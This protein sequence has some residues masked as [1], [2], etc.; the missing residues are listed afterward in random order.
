MIF[1]WNKI[2]PVTTLLL[3]PLPLAEN[4]QTLT[5]PA[6]FLCVPVSHFD[7]FL[8]NFFQFFHETLRTK[9]YFGSFPINNNYVF[10]VL[11]ELPSYTKFS[12]TVLSSNFF[13]SFLNPNIHKN[14]VSLCSR[15]WSLSLLRQ[16][17][18]WMIANN[19]QK[20][21]GSIFFKKKPWL[22]ASPTLM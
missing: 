1:C 13:N 6:L 12:L 22:L 7:K 15:P 16:S 20:R 11:I 14:K 8:I 17:L 5:E 10:E 3:E 9:K 2:S 21:C 19:R 4:R 18:G